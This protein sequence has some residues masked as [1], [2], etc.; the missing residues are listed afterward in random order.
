MVRNNPNIKPPEVQSVFVLSAFREQRDW[1]DLEKAAASAIDKKWISKVKEKVKKD[2]EPHGHNFEAVVSFKEYCDKK[3]PFYI[4]TINDCRGNPDQPSFVFKTSSVKLNIALNMDCDGDHFMNTE[5]CFFDGKRKCRRGFVTLSAIVYHPLLRK[6]ITLA[7]MEAESENHTNVT[8]FGDILNECLRKVSRKTN[9]KF[10][11]IGWCAD[12]A[13][14]NLAGLSEVF[15]ETVTDRIKTSKFHFKDHRNKNA[16]KLDPDSAVE[17]KTLC[18]NLLL[19]ATEGAYE[20]SK[21]EMDAFI[22]AKEERSFL[23]S[24][25]SW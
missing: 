20:R 5:Y 19:S 17:F 21:A 23:T 14:A 24:W 3:D 10:N 13:G 7:T 16:R 12:M 8:L 18:D 22:A 1:R 4:Y 15:G 2:I 6:Q 9:Y 11:P 25:I